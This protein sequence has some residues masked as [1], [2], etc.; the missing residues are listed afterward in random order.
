MGDREAIASR[1]QSDKE[2]EGAG[3][4]LPHDNIV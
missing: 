1:G 3:V 2:V 4:M